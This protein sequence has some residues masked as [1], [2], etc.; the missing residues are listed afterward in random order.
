MQLTKLEFMLQVP[1]YHS[2]YLEARLPNG[3]C[4]NTWSNK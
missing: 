2:M 3:I 1:I 4:K